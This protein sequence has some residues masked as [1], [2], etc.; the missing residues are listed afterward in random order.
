M[1]IVVLDVSEAEALELAIIE[2]VQRVDL[3][4]L[5]E[6]NGYQALIDQFGH[7]QEAIAKIVGKSRSH[8]ANTLAAA[9]VAGAGAGLYPLGQAHRWSRA[10]AD[11]PAERRRIGRADR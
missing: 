8:V 6:A 9:E 1:P 5:E 10:Y 2:N 11:R 4:P 3:N 7:S